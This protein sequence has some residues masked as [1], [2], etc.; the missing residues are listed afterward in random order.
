ML[1]PQPGV[2]TV[3]VST[4]AAWAFR[5]VSLPI[6][7]GLNKWFHN[8]DAGLGQAPWEQQ[9]WRGVYGYPGHR[10]GGWGSRWYHGGMHTL[11]L[12]AMFRSREPLFSIGSFFSRREHRIT[13]SRAASMETASGAP[14]MSAVCCSSTVP[15]ILLYPTRSTMSSL[16]RSASGS[17]PAAR[18]VEATAHVSVCDGTSAPWDGPG[19][20]DAVWLTGQDAL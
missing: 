2:R 8:K 16:G 12:G 19:L 17:D 3:G 5:C 10:R 13:V 6:G 7:Y 18:G 11:S 9:W 4:L 1:P 20:G 14:S 15:C